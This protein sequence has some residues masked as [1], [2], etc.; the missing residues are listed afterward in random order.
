MDKK[1]IIEKYSIDPNQT[2]D[3]FYE[4]GEVS[5]NSIGT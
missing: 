4:N 2:L 3:V 1:T 5:K